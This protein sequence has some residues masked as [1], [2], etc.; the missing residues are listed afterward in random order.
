M[1]SPRYAICYTPPPSSPLACFGAGVLGYDCFERVSVPHLTP[2][3][4][5]PSLPA[6]ATLDVRRYGFRA[7]LVEPFCLSDC[8]EDEIVA[9]LDSFSRAHAPIP[10]G[11]LQVVAI[12]P[13]VALVP[14][15]ADPRLGAFASAC[16]TAFD[17]Y[18]VALASEAERCTSG[19]LAQ[20]G[21]DLLDRDRPADLAYFRMTLTGPLAASE[22]ELFTRLLSRAFAPMASDRVEIDAVS[23]MRQDDLADS[24]FVLAR[25]RLTGR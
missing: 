8:C 25:R 10:V 4:I 11:P 22:V 5:T 7:K 17:P 21:A 15:Q 18:S 13:V 9:R 24:F 14:T 6:L 16:L 1:R 3:R 19:A 12:G 23:L 20:V 2:D